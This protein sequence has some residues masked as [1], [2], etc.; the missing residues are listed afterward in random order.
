LLGNIRGR[1]HLE[2]LGIEGGIIFK[3]VLNKYGGSAWTGFTWLGI[4]ASYQ[5]L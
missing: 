2:D 3:L 1:E 4:G 5:F